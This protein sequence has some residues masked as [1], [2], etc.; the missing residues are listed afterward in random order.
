MLWPKPGRHMCFDSHVSTYA[1]VF[2]YLK[3]LTMRSSIHEAEWKIQFV[4]F[5]MFDN[6]WKMALEMWPDL[7]CLQPKIKA[8]IL[9]GSLFLVG[10]VRQ[11]VNT[12]NTELLVLTPC[13]VSFPKPNGFVPQPTP[14]KQ[15]LHHLLHKLYA[16]FPKMRVNRECFCKEEESAKRSKLFHTVNEYSRN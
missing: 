14:K 8:E 15:T 3:P 5:H 4:G 16:T 9:V 2:N 7:T 12:V 1:D 11:K 6:L 10:V 13:W